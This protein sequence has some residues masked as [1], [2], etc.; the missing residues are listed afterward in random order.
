VIEIVLEILSQHCSNRS[1]I[2]CY[3]VAIESPIQS[4]GVL[5]L[6]YIALSRAFPG[7]S[8]Q[9]WKFVNVKDGSWKDVEFAKEYLSCLASDLELMSP[10]SW[11]KV[12]RHELKEKGGA[13]ILTHYGSLGKGK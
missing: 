12:S 5:L 9:Q 6:I 8:W 1:E 10:E 13:G 4:P 7:S 11:S 2:G 3:S